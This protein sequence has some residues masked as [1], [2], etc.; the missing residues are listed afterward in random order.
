[1]KPVYVNEFG[2]ALEAAF[3]DL[4]LVDPPID[5]ASH[6]YCAGTV[7]R[8]IV[9]ATHHAYA[10]FNCKLRLIVPLS[11]DTLEKLRENFKSL[12]RQDR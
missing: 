11:V 5:G 1:M 6:L 9:S 10:C 8:H 3:G 12:Q 7:D 4:Q 2:E